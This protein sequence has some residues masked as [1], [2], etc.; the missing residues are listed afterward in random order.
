MSNELDSPCFKLSN[1][2]S[3]PGWGKAGSDP[4]WGNTN[5]RVLT[6]RA[7]LLTT[8]PPAR[9][10]RRVPRTGALLLVLLALL[11]CSRPAAA[12]A[13]ALPSVFLGD[14]AGFAVLAGDAVTSTGLTQITGDLG[15]SPGYNANKAMLVV[16]F[17][18]PGVMVGGSAIYA[19]DVAGIALAA[20]TA[21]TTAYNDAAGRTLCVN[22]A[23]RWTT[24]GPGA[25]ISGAFTGELGGL[26]LTPGL[27]HSTSGYAI[28]G[29][30]TLDAQVC[31]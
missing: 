17:N 27:Y 10:L 18:P 2:S 24:A 5:V 3:D 15:V 1:A 16:G 12:D 21:L 30:V 8:R 26:T 7:T 13:C 6:Y 28:T 23:L 22:Q 20:Q 14:A 9:P 25:P 31:Y 19:A 4:G 11:G 29:A